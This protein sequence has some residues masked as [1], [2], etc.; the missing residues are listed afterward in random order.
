[1]T[2]LQV[3]AEILRLKVALFKNGIT[4]ID[5]IDSMKTFFVCYKDFV[6]LERLRDFYFMQSVFANNYAI[7]ID[8][9]PRQ[10][11]LK[12]IKL[13]AVVNP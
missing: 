4:I 8:E 10:R 12:L 13:C 2:I 7:S 3:K 6:L 5:E 1:M 11:Q 9:Q